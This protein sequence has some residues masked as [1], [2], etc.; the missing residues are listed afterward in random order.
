MAERRH[1][2]LLVQAGHIELVAQRA[3]L[4]GCAR[5]V[6]HARRDPTSSLIL[7]EA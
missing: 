6:L 5:V 3:V 2:G 1:A 7:N 4:D